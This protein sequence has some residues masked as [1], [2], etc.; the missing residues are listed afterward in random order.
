MPGRQRRSSEELRVLILEAAREVFARKGY[1][2]TTK[3]DVAEAAGVSLSVLYRH[4]EST[5][6]LFAAA[7]LIPFTQFLDELTAEWLRQREGDWDDR[8]MMRSYLGDLLYQLGENRDVLTGIVAAAKDIDSDVLS[9]L[10]SA[11]DDLI[12]RI[13]LMGELEAHRRGWFSP[14]GL[15][16]VL[17]ILVGMVLG[18]VTYDWLLIKPG[19]DSERLLDDMVDLALWGLARKPPAHRLKE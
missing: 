13:G 15:D 11:V 9:K 16:S 2:A 3:R 7:A 19:T 5:A 6:D 10:T 8:A 14:T 4:F 1:A 17:R 18:A 12:D